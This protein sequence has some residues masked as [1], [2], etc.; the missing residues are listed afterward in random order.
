MLTRR[1][2]LRSTV[3]AAAAAPTATALAAPAPPRGSG[4][5]R[6]LTNLDHLRFLLAEVPLP[7]TD[8]HS[9]FDD[10]SPT[11][12]AP[13]TYADRATD[14][15]FTRV[16]GGDLDPAT[17][18]WSQGA[19]NADDIS[20]AAIVFL[21]A[22]AAF[23][24]QADLAVARELLRTLTYLQVD[25]GGH[26][27]NVV[28]WQQSD[29][30]LNRSA[31]PVELPV[32]SDSDESY[33]LARTVWALGEGIAGFARTDP[34][35]TAFLRERL[36]LALDALERASLGRYGRWEV[37]D[38]VAV[39]GWLIAG[40]ADATG[41]A[42]LGLV[43]A[44]QVFPEDSRVTEALD[45][46]AEGIAAM[47]SG[48]VGVWPF[49]A[50]LPWTGSQSFWHAW[51][52]LAPAAL[53]AAAP[54]IGRGLEE[55][56][57]DA[58][59]FTPQL[60]TSGGPHNAWSPVPGEAQIAYGVQCRVETLL[61]TADATGGPGLRELAALVAGWFFGANP[62]G[63]R[64]YDPATG[65]TVDGI[66]P[67]GTV[68]RNSG[69]EST[70]HALLTMIA[71]DREKKLARTAQRLTATPEHHGMQWLPAEEA[72]LGTGAE[73][74]TPETA[75]TGESNW[76]GAYVLAPDGASV[77]FDLEE[78]A[79]E[80][81]ARGGATAHPLFHR[82][83]EEAGTATWTALAADGTRT[84]LGT[85]ELGGAGERGVT[86]WDGVLTP[87]RLDVPLPARTVAVEVVSGGRLELDEL[88]LLPAVTVAEFP[89]EHG[90]NVMLHAASADAELSLVSGRTGSA[91]RAEGTRVGPVNHGRRSV[92]G[93]EFA[94]TRG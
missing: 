22:H 5:R 35:F 41:E 45:R 14:G 50:V 91:Y 40:G 17:G 82:L 87:V 71:L 83:A 69:A 79:L 44:L 28:L 21:R 49:G 64:V 90:R 74:I 73:V 60:L 86:P 1:T 55:A 10:S 76:H 70:I 62:A 80:A 4:G 24:E 51:G 78:G 6:R 88:M 56:V 68:N 48:G 16:G 84:V 15:T 27:G 66:E 12:L 93:G 18:H 2:L 3:L 58:G 7:P 31:I 39:P 59:V 29:G 9:R 38:G 43:A 75:W 89:L 52:G 67:D 72:Q 13:W 26:A 8:G 53:A 77:R 25:S 20:R 32:P 47:A 85:L 37:A 36:H 30:S 61:R 65:A 46:F 94:I 57:A 33:W 23:A 11:G 81:V 42:V 34:D 63:Q 19:F 92:L 54:V